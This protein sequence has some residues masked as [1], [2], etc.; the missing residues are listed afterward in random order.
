MRNVDTSNYHIPISRA[1]KQLGVTAKT[2]RNWEA[3]GQLDCIRINGR[4]Y[5]SQT[6]VDALLAKAA[7]TAAAQQR[8]LQEAAARRKRKAQCNG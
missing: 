6:D 7:A 8:Q 1:A 3:R 2:L 4:R 5:I